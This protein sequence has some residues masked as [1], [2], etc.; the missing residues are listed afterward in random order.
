MKLN[1]KF[2]TEKGFKAFLILL[3]CSGL[4]ALF[5]D[6]F[7]AVFAL[8]IAGFIFYDYKKAKDVA[9]KINN[10][11][12]LN[13]N[14]I[15]E[16]LVAGKKKTVELSCQVNTA[17]PINLSS[18]LKEARLEP[19]R[20]R[21]GKYNL[22]LLL[23]SDISGNYTTDKLKAEVLGPCKLAQKEGDI[24]FNLELKVFPRVIVALI[25]AALFL[26]REGRGGV[27]EIPIP[28]KGPGTEYAETREYVSGDS[29]RHID[30]KAT[31]RYGKLMVK[32]FFQEAGQGAHIIYDT[33]GIGPISQDKLATNFLNAC[34]GVVEQGYPVGVTVH[35]GKKVLLHSIEESPRQ[36]L[37]MA[38]GY[39]LQNMKALLEDIDVLIDPVSSSQIRRFLNKV[40]EE[41]VRKFLE[42]E[43]KIIQDR[44]GEPYKFL[45]QLSHQLNEERQF[46]LISQLSGEIVELLEF[47]EKI[48]S[49]HQLTIIQPTEP[50]REAKDVESAY[51]WYKRI[52]GVEKI[53]G[54]HKIR[55]IS[56]LRG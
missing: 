16:V 31:A 35:D 20:L 29:L 21:K 36:I 14:N 15:R 22:K 42:F 44:L 11:I 46:L 43:T 40:K 30:W 53:L 26:L 3:G 34:L 54:Q 23:S 32:E 5:A 4:A 7:L 50:W 6:I 2:L 9:G 13:S 41:Q 37:K 27:G 24:S 8:G 19:T 45:T 17:L 55:V 56:R 1:T 52:K 39:V 48:Q 25:Q 49:R 12:K 33:R 10:L 47:A 28:F 51:R 18:P 38:M